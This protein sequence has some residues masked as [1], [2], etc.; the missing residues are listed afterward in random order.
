MKWKKKKGTLTIVSIY[1]YKSGEWHQMILTCWPVQDVTGRSV[2]VETTRENYNT[3]YD[4][5]IVCYHLTQQLTTNIKCIPWNDCEIVPTT[6]R[7]AMAIYLVWIPHWLVV[8]NPESFCWSGKEN[9]HIDNTQICSHLQVLSNTQNLQC[10]NQALFITKTRME[11][12]PVIDF[13]IEL[14]M[15]IYSSLSIRCSQA[16]TKTPNFLRHVR[17]C[18]IESML[19]M[20][21]TLVYI[22]VN[23]CSG[24]TFQ[25]NNIIFLKC[26][27]RP[28]NVNTT[29][30]KPCISHVFIMHILAFS[31]VFWHTLV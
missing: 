15:Y 4:R 11:F 3:M 19:S 20:T 27:F 1:L 2:L 22:H 18:L 29:C 6:P 5:N 24:K 23:R 28:M 10:T 14:D 8:G 17:S 9:V 31:P 16:A 21:C 30:M 12:L 25:K 26:F 7:F 13:L